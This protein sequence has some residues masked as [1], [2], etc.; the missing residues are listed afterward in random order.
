MPA[1]SWAIPIGASRH[2][3]VAR[4]KPLLTEKLKQEY[5][6]YQ[7]EKWNIHRQRLVISLTEHGIAP[8]SIVFVIS[9]SL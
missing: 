5:Q 7:V 9:R 1:R 6:Q 3:P 4:L 2:G 8:G